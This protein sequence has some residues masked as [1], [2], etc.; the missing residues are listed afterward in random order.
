ME[1]VIQITDFLFTVTTEQYRAVILFKDS[2]LCTLEGLQNG[3]GR[4]DE[5]IRRN[6][7]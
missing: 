5:V 3:Q 6:L 7:P 4:L 2:K 1:G